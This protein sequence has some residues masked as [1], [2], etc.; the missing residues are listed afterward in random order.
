MYINI[1]MTFLINWFG[2]IVQRTTGKLHTVADY[3]MTRWC[4][5]HSINKKFYRNQDRNIRTV[6]G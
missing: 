4:N 2:P 5:M 6:Y 1:D 3:H